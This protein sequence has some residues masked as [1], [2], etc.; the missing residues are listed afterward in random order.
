MNACPFSH[1]TAHTLCNPPPHTHTCTTHSFRSQAAAAPVAGDRPVGR[2]LAG[3][4]G[5]LQDT[6]ALKA[7]TEWAGR[8]NEKRPVAL[9]GLEDVYTGGTQEGRLA[10]SI[11][12]ALTQR[13]EFGRV[14]TPKER[15]RTL[16]HQFHGIFPSK[17]KE[18]HRQR[19]YLEDV[20]ARQR[21]TAAPDASAELDRLRALQQRL[22]APYVPLDGKAPLPGGAGGGGDDDDVG[23]EALPVARGGGGKGGGSGGK[24]RLGGST[25]PL[26]GD[27]KVAAMLGLAKPPPGGAG[28][29]GGMPPPRPKGR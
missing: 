21:A 26:L 23:G 18:A 10:R 6:G 13:D 15:F 24:P 22:G 16:C 27:A 14:M 4:L 7:H 25:A 11:E 1:A 3:A 28:G 5:L 2:G 9:A 19:K 8:T 12:A 29:S 17:N 20:A